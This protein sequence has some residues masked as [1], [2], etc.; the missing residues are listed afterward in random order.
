MISVGVAE[1]M[2]G[3]TSG[4]DGF[5]LGWIGHFAYDADGGSGGDVVGAVVAVARAADGGGGTAPRRAIEVEEHANLWDG[6]GEF[7]FHL[8]SVHAVEAP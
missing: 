2:A 3:L 6:L 8:Y 7:V 1:G 4:H 5:H